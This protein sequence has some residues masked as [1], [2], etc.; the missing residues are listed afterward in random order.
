MTFLGAAGL[1]LIL[2][3][4]PPKAKAAPWEQQWN[5]ARAL[6]AALDYEAALP[7]LK[8]LVAEPEIPPGPRA[9]ILVDL[10]LAYVNLGDAAGATSAFARA[11]TFDAGVALPP[12]A[13]PKAVQL[14]D[15]ERRKLAPLS[16]PAPTRVEEPPAAAP[17]VAPA[18]P[19]PV[20]VAP[21]EPVPELSTSPARRHFT[22]PV[23]LTGV[24]AAGVLAAGIGLALVSQGIAT[25]LAT[26]PRPGAEVTAQLSR[27][28]GF[29]AGAITAYVVSGA[30]AILCAVL[31][32]RGADEIVA[33]SSPQPVASFAQ[34]P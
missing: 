31:A 26:T 20:V 14:F 10:A 2:A 24:S 18:T 6:S 28:D 8:L 27:R 1:G 34:W 12:L 11:L 7:M 15:Q 33:S 4:A 16:P 29:S 3:V 5:K 25:D 32:I 19:A 13:P 30:L 17:S 21:P 9:Q 22:V 23:L